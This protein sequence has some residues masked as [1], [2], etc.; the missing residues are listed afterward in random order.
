MAS[1]GLSSP[2]TEG[3]MGLQTFS[4]KTR[5]VQ[6][7]GVIGHPTPDMAPRKKD[8]SGSYRENALKG[9]LPRGPEPILGHSGGG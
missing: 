9:K 5:S 3:F 4:A 1:N 7:R 6:D 8:C 2:G